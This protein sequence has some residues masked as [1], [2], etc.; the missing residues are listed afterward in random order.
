MTLQEINDLADLMRAAGRQTIPVPISEWR[1][2]MATRIGKATVKDGKV[3]P[4]DR[5]PLPA[6]IGRKAKADRI[7]K[8]LRANREKAKR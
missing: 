2:M 6:K 7:E 5:A 4:V 1:E 8:G 3:K